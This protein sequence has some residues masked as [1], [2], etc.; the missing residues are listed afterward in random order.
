MLQRE[1]GT[2]LCWLELQIHTFRGF[3]Q[4]QVETQASSVV[5]ILE[6]ALEHSDSFR[7]LLAGQLHLLSGV[8]GRVKADGNRTAMLCLL[9]RGFGEK[10]GVQVRLLRRCL[11]QL[12]VVGTKPAELVVL[13][14]RLQQEAVV[15]SWGGMDCS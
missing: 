15:G 11:A 7:N 14:G 4:E 10:I 13:V 8:I 9:H 2:S 1:L 6:K 12:I 3:F 5:V